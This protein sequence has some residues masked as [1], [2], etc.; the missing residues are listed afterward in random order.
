MKIKN[1]ILNDKSTLNIDMNL[2]NIN[3]NK[4]F[5]F[6]DFQIKDEVETQFVDKEEELGDND[7]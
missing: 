3:P 7:D 2:L 6:D 4:G 1:I 5:I